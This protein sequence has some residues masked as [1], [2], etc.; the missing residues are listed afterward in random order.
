MFLQRSDSLIEVELKMSWSPFSPNHIAGK[1]SMSS[2][3]LDKC[4]I[5]MLLSMEIHIYH[6]RFIPEGLAELSQIFLR[7]TRTLP[8]RFNYEKRSAHRISDVSVVNPLGHLYTSV[9][10]TGR[11][12][13][14]FTG[15]PVDYRL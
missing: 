7:D 5:S 15:C 11:R 14:F 6:S 8:K 1:T 3:R 4:V 10:Y 13:V 12:A 2:F 9:F